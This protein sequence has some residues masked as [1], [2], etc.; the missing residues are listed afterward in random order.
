MN[1]NLSR[2][3][4]SSSTGVTPRAKENLHARGPGHPQE[5]SASARRL[6][7][8]LSH[9]YASARGRSECNCPC[10]TGREIMRR[11]APVR[12]A[13]TGMTQTARLL[14]ERS[15]A[16]RPGCELPGNLWRHVQVAVAGSVRLIDEGTSVRGRVLRGDHRHHDLGKSLPRAIEFGPLSRSRDCP[17]KQRCPRGRDHRD[18]PP[19]RFHLDLR[20][21]RFGSKAHIRVHRWARGRQRT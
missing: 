8:A 19:V 5:R 12:S 1:R 15:T 6:S 13:P 3:A 20:R 2:E 11:Y 7:M 18:H 14:G 16:D 10:V 17:G 9:E 21:N 4:N